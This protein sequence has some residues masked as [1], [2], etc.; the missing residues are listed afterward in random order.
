M[1]VLRALH[2]R[3]AL[4][5]VLLVFVASCAQFSGQ[6][7]G[8]Q[9][10]VAAAHPLAVDA[11]YAVLERGG[12]ALDA[13]IAVQL[14]LGLVEPESSGI[15]GG[16]FLLYWSES[17]KRLRSYDGR[18]TAPAAARADR[19]LKEDKT[20]MAFVEAV[21]GGRS[22]G[23]PGVLRMLELAH[24]RH[25]KLPWSELFQPAIAAAEGGFALSPR[26]QSQLARDTF[27]PR[28]A[29]ARSIFYE[30]GK[31]KPA[32][33][34]IV[35]RQYAETLRAIANKGVDAFYRGEI[36]R[37]IVR[38]VRSNAKPGDLTE[39]D[40]EGYR[41]LEREPLCGPYREWRVCSMAPPSAGGVAVLQILGILERTN[42]ARAPP[43]SVDALHL[44]SEAGR[45]AYADRAK[46]L[47]DPAFKNVPVG[48]L[49][50]P[51]YLDARA[52]LIGERSMRTASPGD[53][54]ALGTS[55]I[56][57]VDAQGNVASMTTT[58]EATFGSRI[59]VRGFLL[60]NE[61]TDFD[62]VPGSANEVAPG[63][64][65]RSSMA[66]T[67]VFDSQGAVRLA[68]GSPGG[69]NIINYVAKALVAMLDWRFDAQ[70]AAAAPNFGSRNG[71]TLLE[72]GA[73]YEAM[74]GP[75]EARGHAVEA[76][77]LTSGVHAVERVPGGWR[78]G[79]DPRREGTVRG[80]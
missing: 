49:L 65:P 30:G 27:L 70:A 7:T 80:K 67:I 12:S 47:G 31:A 28:D 39:A 76:N 26:L 55:H 53:T 57:I 10:V 59:M 1:V 25:G 22:V 46:Y 6:E 15:G 37:D 11:G 79:A 77:P 52:R 44:F 51:K 42:F 73:F 14:V 56:S 78:G 74:K 62:F 61:L 23:V 75:L 34:S 60:N 16:A 63:K 32:G 19:F 21:V 72:A 29:A 5:A 41:A 40:L 69:P 3:T 33:A 50:D 20:P 2:F 24:A 36:A 64:R 35:N 45:L 66:P 9:F 13:A 71:P 68:V 4:A 38:A 54:E 18:E 17:E 58:I 48:R 43:L 8:K